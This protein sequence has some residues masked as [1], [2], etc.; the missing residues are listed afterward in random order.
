MRKS[1]CDDTQGWVIKP[2][3]WVEQWRELY[4][5]KAA[6]CVA[7]DLGAPLRTVEKWFSGESK[8]SFEY[9]GPILNRYG[10][11]FVVG[12]MSAPLPYLDDLARED[13]KRRL[14]AE[15]QAIDVMLAEDWQRRVGS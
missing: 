7:T 9:W 14:L 4:P 3:R 11:A 12:A 1:G 6:Q 13:R 2:H 5:S 15:R 8:P 10:L